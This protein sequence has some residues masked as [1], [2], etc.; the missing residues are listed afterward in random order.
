MRRFVSVWLPQWPIE[1][2]CRA[3]PGAVPAEAPLALVESLDGRLTLTA[4][5][6]AARREGLGP[7]L[8]LA[9][10]R[11]AVPALAT[12][13]AEPAAD[14]VALRRLAL[15]MSRYGV[16][17]ALEHFPTRWPPGSSK[18]MRPGKNP[19]RSASGDPRRRQAG[20]RSGEVDTGAPKD[21]APRQ[22]SAAIDAPDGIGIEITG[23]AHLFGGEKGLLADLVHR[24]A[25][26]GLTVRPGLADTPGAAFAVARAVQS[27]RLADRI[28]P[29]GE[30]AVHLAPLPVA[31]LRLTPE[32]QTLLHRLGLK[33]IGNLTGVPRASL[34]R[35]F[36]SRDVT[37]AVLTRLDQ[38]FGL[39]GE[40][41]KSLVPPARYI[42]RLTFAEPLVSSEG[43]MAALGTLTE[44]LAGDLAEAQAG[45]RRLALA[46]YRSD[47]SLVR[48]PVGLSRPSREAAHFRRLLADKLLSV[49]LGFGVDLMTLTA[50]ESEPLAAAQVTLADLT[51]DA[52]GGTALL[53]DR[54][55]SRLGA[56]R[57]LR[58]SPRASHVP[59]VA[60]R[61]VPALAEAAPGPLDPPPL[62]SSFCARSDGEPVST[63]PDRALR[64]GARPP[65][66]LP[67]P[68]PVAVVAEIPDGPPACLE[69]RRRRRRIVRAAGPERIAPEWWQPLF[70][71]APDGA[72][73]T[74][75][76]RLGRTRDYYTVEDE[77]GRRYWVFREGLYG[78]EEG[79]APPAWY[80]HGLFA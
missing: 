43:V 76:R 12:L 70:R 80:L 25:G 27:R 73:E 51:P 59:E 72:A 4:L 61:L 55:A 49:D 33:T 31:A 20:A 60:E 30:T 37:A 3:S 26:F 14:L 1:R 69:W 16:R 2:L 58:L 29:P 19:E 65:F 13:P 24:L 39:A 32:T 5:N 17:I 56:D 53:I 22:I 46:L 79:E 78:R 47:G 74:A 62:E 67:H 38:A 18:K 21:R 77:D 11:A 34:E 66:L 28:V 75:A 35:R 8:A 42:A 9:D 64:R 52:G 44:R 7:G 15:W 68:E 45:A 6:R 23:V 50:P 57:V 48:L 40:P 10:A 54:L 36:N 41:T 63:S 71:P